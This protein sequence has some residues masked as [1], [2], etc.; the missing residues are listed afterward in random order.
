MP[1]PLV[2]PAWQS[3]PM[4]PAAG[5]LHWKQSFCKGAEEAAAAS[6]HLP[7]PVHGAPAGPGLHL[8]LGLGRV[9]SHLSLARR[10]SSAN[11]LL[12]SAPLSASSWTPDSNSQTSGEVCRAVCTKERLGC[13]DPFSLRSLLLKHT[14]TS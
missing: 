8:G 9:C 11:L 13:R 1:V 12:A 3:V 2:C 7:L 14:Q 4:S 10:R 6:P 5:L